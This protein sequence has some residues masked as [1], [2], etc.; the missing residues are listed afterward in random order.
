M[1][2]TIAQAPGLILG[3]IGWAASA[4]LICEASGISFLPRAGLIIFTWM[5][6]M[7]PAFDV[8]VHQGIMPANIAITF[9]TI[10]TASLVFVVSLTAFHQRRNKQ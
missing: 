10:T 7:I 1:M 6:W 9:C 2:D 3:I 4:R 8:V 5:L